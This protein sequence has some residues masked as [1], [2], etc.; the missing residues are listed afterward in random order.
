MSQTSAS[1]KRY[2][3][4]ITDEFFT[5]Y[6]TLDNK[7]NINILNKFI[8]LYR[9]TIMIG[10]YKL[11]V[12]LKHTGYGILSKKYRNNNKILICNDENITMDE[13][14]IEDLFKKITSK[15]I[16]QEIK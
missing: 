13:F 10:N 3:K 14:T 1:N 6:R 4:D 9:E 15:H 7:F 2:H 5:L 11:L 16:I 12:T 8:Y